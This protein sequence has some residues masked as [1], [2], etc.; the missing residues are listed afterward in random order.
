MMRFGKFTKIAA[1]AGVSGALILP[2]TAAHAGD[3]T[4]RAI[5]GAVLGG[6]AGAAVSDGDGAGVAIGAA[7]GAALG[8]ATAK[9]NNRRYSRSYRSSRSYAND[10]RY[11]YS[12]PAYGYN[13]GYYAPQY[14]SRPA[15]NRGY[16]DQY[17][18]YRGY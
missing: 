4:E 11:R 3:K 5:I 17:G 6:I 16:Y 12:Q 1:A 8:A 9:D 2:A 7:A 13:R 15:Y 10:N 18:A 14:R